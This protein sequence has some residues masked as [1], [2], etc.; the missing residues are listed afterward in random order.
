MTPVGRRND[1]GKNFARPPAESSPLWFAFI[2]SDTKRP[3]V[4]R[5]S[6][7]LKLRGHVCVQLY[8]V[9]KP[10]AAIWLPVAGSSL[11]SPTFELLSGARM[12]AS[13][14][15]A[16]RLV[17]DVCVDVAAAS[18]LPRSIY[19][20]YFLS[21]FLPRSHSLS[22]LSVSL[23]PQ[24]CVSQSILAWRLTWG[25]NT[26]QLAIHASTLPPP[27]SSHHHSQPPPSSPLHCPISPRSLSQHLS[28]S[29]DLM[30]FNRHVYLPLALLS[31]S[32]LWLWISGILQTN[33]NNN[34]RTSPAP[35]PPSPTLP[36]P[37]FLNQ[38]L[39]SA[40]KSYNFLTVRRVR[41]RHI[42]LQL[43]SLFSAVDPS[44]WRRG[45]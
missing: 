38:Y 26:S 16:S 15:M 31:P 14:R 1:R 33:N 4:S 11:C 44:F 35:P 25:V 9:E 21:F 13:R 18:S 43:V 28:Q 5:L 2:T 45:Y 32:L 22:S 19:L 39:P 34:N 10:D 29:S 12:F 27:L 20:Q 8:I 7:R 40:N 6:R 24:A 36:S 41:R 3:S 17:C 30:H 42:Y 37:L 23:R